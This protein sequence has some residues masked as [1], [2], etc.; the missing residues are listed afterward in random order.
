MLHNNQNPYTI[1]LIVP[2]KEAIRKY[3]ENNNLSLKKQEDQDKIIELIQNEI[4]KFKTGGEYEEQFPDRWLPT[5]IAILGEGFTEENKMLN[6]TLKIVRRKIE[7][8]YSER[9]DYLY[10]PEGKNIFNQQNRN[11]ISKL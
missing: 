9:I 6:S 8:Y 2:N 10:T 5:T 11:I 1:G 3:A 4:N 7:K